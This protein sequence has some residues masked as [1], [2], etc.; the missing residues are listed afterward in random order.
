MYKWI[1]MLKKSKLDEI[2]EWNFWLNIT[3]KVLHLGCIAFTYFV[4]YITYKCVFFKP[5]LKKRTAHGS[6]IVLKTG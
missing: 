1:I 3:G 2:F 4:L 6:L 5:L